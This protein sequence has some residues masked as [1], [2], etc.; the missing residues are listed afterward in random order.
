MAFLI[1][2][3]EAGYGPNLGPMLVTATL[4]QIEDSADENDWDLWPLFGDKIG[5]NSDQILVGD[6]KDIFKS[7]QGSIQALEKTV[8]VFC[9]LLG[10]KI[11]CRPN[12]IIRLLLDDSHNSSQERDREYWQL[13][14]DEAVPHESTTDEILTCSRTIKRQLSDKCSLLNVYSSAIFPEQFNSGIER[15]G[16]KAHL[17][18]ETT[19]KLVEK[20]V[21]VAKSTNS[22]DRIIVRCDKHGGRSKYLPMIHEHLQDFLDS[23]F[24]EVLEESLHASRYQAFSTGQLFTI[25]FRSKGE[26]DL[27][28]ATSSMFSKY[29][30]EMYMRQWNKFWRRKIPDLKP[31]AGYPVDAKRFKKQ[32]SKI[33]TELGIKND[34]IWRIK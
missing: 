16:N 12:D 19:M 14:S 5:T 23:E 1:G 15:L 27:A 18:S 6:S 21:T 31:T 4:W 11:P 17:L 25:D 10:Q 26:R 29:V 32:I 8:L 20:A 13:S 3:D 34:S 30:R 7:T 9:Q 2:T 22:T 24:V 28:I 33:Q